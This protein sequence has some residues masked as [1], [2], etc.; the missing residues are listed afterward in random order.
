[1]FQRTTEAA[2]RLRSSPAEEP[3]RALSDA[4]VVARLRAGDVDAL[5]ALYDR[6]SRRAY[7]VALSVCHDDG[8]AQEAVQDAFLSL[9]KSSATYQPERGVFAAW[10]LAGV[11]H[12][13]IDLVRR[14]AKHEA[15]RADE[16]QL[17]RVAGPDDVPSRSISRED[18]ERLRTS[19]RSL[20][21]A[22]Q[23]VIQLAFYAQLSH[24]EIAAQL[25]LPSGTV[26]GR[27]R[28]GLQK[29]RADIAEIRPDENRLTT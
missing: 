5:A 6:Y 23:E 3:D 17:E 27:M 19:L 20:P 25:G 12:R 1:M 8:R 4:S 18:D 26:K 15:R 10:L 24:R 21:E 13:A 22:Q 7:A 28:L 2:E 16:G 29:L 14:N 9:W 11:R